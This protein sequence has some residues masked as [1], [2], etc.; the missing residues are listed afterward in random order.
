[1]SLAT[2]IERLENAAG[3]KHECIPGLEIRFIEPV[4]DEDGR[5]GPGRCTGGLR[6]LPGGGQQWLDAD[7]KPIAAMA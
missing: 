7:M 2:R 6:F 4:R 1:M 5:M 3:Q